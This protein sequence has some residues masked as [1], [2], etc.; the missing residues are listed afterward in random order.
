MKA[1]ISSFILV[2]VSSLGIVLPANAKDLAKVKDRVITDRDLEMSLSA[3]NEGQRAGVLRDPNSRR[4]ILQRLIDMEVLSLEGEKLKLDQEPAFKEA[5]MRFRKQ[6]LMNRVL[7]KSLASKLTQSEAKKYYEAHKDRYSTDQVHV[8]HILVSDE[9]EA[10]KILKLA[11]EPNADFQELAEKHSIDPSA[12]NNRGEVGFIARDGMASEFTDVAFA[13]KEGEVSAPVKT[14]YGYHII[15]LLERKIG[16][17][18]EFDEVEL[19]VRGDLQR[20]V[21]R[22]F[23]DG[24]KAQ[25]PIKVD[26]AAIDKY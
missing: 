6:L 22:G 10:R 16:K 1:K 13:L 14:L 9:N 18:L 5:L 11:K 19:R 25:Y 26:Q 8:Q 23:T 4:Q 12:K 2:C 3:L 17:P 21:E 15:K 7:E 20:Q 24:I